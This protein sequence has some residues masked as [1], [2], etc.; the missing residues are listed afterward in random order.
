M[1]KS[2]CE[3]CGHVMYDNEMSIRFK[4][5]KCGREFRKE[6]WLPKFREQIR[7]AMLKKEHK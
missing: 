3:W 6:L 7:E 4:C 2:V 1:V 5:N